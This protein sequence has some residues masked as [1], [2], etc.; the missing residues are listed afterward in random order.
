LGDLAG[1]EGVPLAPEEAGVVAGVERF[2]EKA[3]GEPAAIRPPEG[4]AELSSYTLGRTASETGPPA[5]QLFPEAMMSKLRYG[6]GRG[7]ISTVPDR[8]FGVV[9]RER[10]GTE[11][12]KLQRQMQNIDHIKHLLGVQ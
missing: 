10:W 5:T 8:G 4:P 6:E 7:P 12:A 2:A 1:V 9:P 11:T 3:L